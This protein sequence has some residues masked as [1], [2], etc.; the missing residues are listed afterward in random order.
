MEVILVRAGRGLSRVGRGLAH[1][2]KKAWAAIPERKRPAPTPVPDA[3]PKLPI[4]T[5]PGPRAGAVGTIQSVYIRDPDEN[6]V[7][8][9]NY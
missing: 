1:A 6:L 7:E 2:A 4:I 8:I 3:K 9:S 5:G